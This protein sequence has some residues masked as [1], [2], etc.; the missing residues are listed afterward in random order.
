M[1]FIQSAFCND[2][3]HLTPLDII[4]LQEKG[5]LESQ[6]YIP[7]I[8]KLIGAKNMDARLNNKIRFL[9]GNWPNGK[10]KLQVR[11]V[12]DDGTWSDWE[13][14]ESVEDVTTCCENWVRSWKGNMDAQDYGFCP[15]CGGKLA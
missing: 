8:V 3:L 15:T 11:D 1:K 7:I 10:F 5:I 4:V 6:D 12:N 14:V 9:E 2:E 13:D